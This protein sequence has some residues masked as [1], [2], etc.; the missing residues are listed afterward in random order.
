MSTEELKHLNKPWIVAVWP[1]MGHV[2]L[3]AGYYLMAKL[4]MELF[5]EISAGDLFDV[6]SVEIKDGILQAGQLPRSRF[7]VWRD[8]EK[9]HDLILF[10]G[11]AQPPLGKYR[12]CQRLIELA[13]GWGVER[14]ITFASLA[15]DTGLEEQARVFCTTSSAE[16]LQSLRQQGLVVLEQGQI[17]GLNGVLLAAA[18]EAGIESACLLGEMPQMFAQVPYPKA[19]LAVLGA[20]AKVSGLQL[21]LHELEQQTN[22]MNSRLAELLARFEK[23]A[24]LA[25]DQ[26]DQDA[27]EQSEF[28]TSTDDDDGLSAADREQLET[29]FQ[30]SAADRSKAYELKRELDRLEVYPEYENRFLDLFKQR[31]A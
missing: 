23:Q 10:I 20:F 1:G 29:L 8:P 18:V 27:E 15:T 24:G 13:K 9:K 28:S 17:S 11:E 25:F 30:E 14:V 2:S 19:A 12:F 6:E 4:H 21:D 7:F 26:E 16:L 31:A 5:A 3:S 22:I